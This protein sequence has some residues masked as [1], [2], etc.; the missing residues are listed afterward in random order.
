MTTTPAPL[1][2]PATAGTV[3]ALIRS[4]AASTRAAVG[5]VTGLSRTAVSAR[6][7]ALQEAGLVVEGGEAPSGGGRPPT[8]L[9]FDQRAGVVLAVAVGRSRS[10]L[11]VCDLAGE[12]LAGDTA[13]HEPGLGPDELLPGILE[14][15]SHLLDRAG[16]AAAEVRAVGVSIPGAVDRTRGASL[17]CPVLPGWD[18]VPLA[19]YFR[20]L[21]EAPVFLDNDA[22]V[23]AL[24][25][26][27][28]HL[29]DFDNL[30]LVKASTGLG[31]GIVVDGALVRGA[32]GAAGEL[33]HVKAPAAAGLA[34]RCGEEGCLEAVAGGWALVQELRDAG[35]DVGHVRELV[36]LALDGDADARALIRVAG[37][38]V[39]EALAAAV[40]LLN[41]GAVVLGGDLAAAYD[42]FVAGVRAGLYAHAAPVVTRELQV[43]QSTHGAEAGVV[44]CAR[45]A[46]DVVLDPAHVDRM[47]A[48]R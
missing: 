8:M 38:H 26:R 27:G 20:Q 32:W 16:R 47:L 40:D 28:E 29:D 7:T 18:G 1:P 3:L 5:A 35:R 4:G 43:L 45:M 23:L 12:V 17:D 15:C 14:R 42:T 46:L 41:P 22:N 13:D 10:Q 44:G 6:I 2:A 33:G 11:A 36:E 31:A 48:E 21:T 39:G 19:P 34:C 9:R 25:E 24:S 37:R 30:L